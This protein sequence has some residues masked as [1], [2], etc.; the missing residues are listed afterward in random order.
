MLIPKVPGKILWRK[1]RWGEAGIFAWFSPFAVLGIF[2]GSVIVSGVIAHGDK[3]NDPPLIAKKYWQ[4]YEER[5]EYEI[6]D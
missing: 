3:K 1:V 6:L 5:N 4:M 2:F